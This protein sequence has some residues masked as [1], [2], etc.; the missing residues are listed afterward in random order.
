MWLAATAGE[1]RPLWA[2]FRAFK[3]EPSTPGK[4]SA[5][6]SVPCKT[7]LP[8][9]RSSLRLPE[10]LLGST[11]RSLRMLKLFVPRVDA[12]FGRHRRLLEK[13]EGGL[14]WDGLPNISSAV[15][16]R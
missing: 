1:A 11:R 7:E 9:M 4:M 3:A 6:L 10:K 14:P 16:V 13:P 8:A 15:I 5:R 2:P 12:L